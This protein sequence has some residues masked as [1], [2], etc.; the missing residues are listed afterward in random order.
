[1]IR[2]RQ[3]KTVFEQSSKVP[4]VLELNKVLVR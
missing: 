4:V 3:P 1:L 2:H